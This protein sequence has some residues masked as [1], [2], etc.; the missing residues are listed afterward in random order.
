MSQWDFEDLMDL[1][2]DQ[3]RDTGG[4]MDVASEGGKDSWLIGWQ[5]LA[6]ANPFSSGFFDDFTIFPLVFPM[7]FPWVFL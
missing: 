2:N 5:I 3:G 6:Y 7:I 1:L 4:G